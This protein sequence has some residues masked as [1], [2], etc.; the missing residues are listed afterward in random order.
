V[1]LDL[2]LGFVLLELEVLVF[3]SLPSVNASW[4]SRVAMISA[5]KEATN[6]ASS[7]GNL[8]PGMSV[9]AIVE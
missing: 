9:I 6:P 7:L 4:S 8:S 5:G 2:L 3:R 1:D